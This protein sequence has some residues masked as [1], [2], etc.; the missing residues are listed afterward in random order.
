[1]K[2]NLTKLQKWAADYIAK[3]HASGWLTRE[4][5]SGAILVVCALFENALAPKHFKKEVFEAYVNERYIF[6]TSKRN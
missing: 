5:K 2:K 6:Y 4:E 3:E 1:M